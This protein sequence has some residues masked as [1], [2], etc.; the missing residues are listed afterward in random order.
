VTDVNACDDT[1]N[2]LLDPPKT[3][4]LRTPLDRLRFVATQNGS[5]R[6][7]TVILIAT[8]VAAAGVVWW[9]ARNGEQTAPDYVGQASLDAATW[10][11]HSDATVG[12]SLRYPGRWHL[13]VVE[14]SD[15]MCQGPS[16]LV[17]NFDADLH[18]PDLGPGSCTGAWD[19]RN[20]RT[21]FVVVEIE[22]PADVPPGP[23]IS[24]R[25]TP[26]SLEDALQG[27]RMAR[28]GVPKGIYIPVFI[29]EG[30]QY[31]VRVWTGP[32]ATSQDYRIA[33]G[34]VGSMRFDAGT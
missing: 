13:Q 4:H 16:V 31:I 17:T 8:F 2:D 32:D 15:D 30:H 6:R 26:L 5:M 24:Q 12:W 34:I 28:F 9:L 7:I 27:S 20:L 19:M 3:H 11:N 1:R 22:V 25:T 14:P 33:D 21:D 23:E 18:H 10:A 29:D